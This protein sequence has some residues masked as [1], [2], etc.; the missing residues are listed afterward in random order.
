MIHG[1]STKWGLNI[2]ITKMSMKW[3]IPSAEEIIQFAG[4]WKL[5]AVSSIS[6]KTSS[7]TRRTASHPCPAP[8][9]QEIY[10]VCYCSSPFDPSN[11]STFFC[12]VCILSKCV[13]RGPD[14]TKPGGSQP[15]ILRVSLNTGEGDTISCKVPVLSQ[16]QIVPLKLS[17][18]PPP[19]MSLWGLLCEHTE[20]VSLLQLE[21]EAALLSKDVCEDLPTVMTTEWS[22]EASPFGRV[23]GCVVIAVLG[24]LAL[25]HIF[26]A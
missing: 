17:Y 26:P 16:P 21:Q 5:K 18:F 11:G 9:L 6:V 1:K 23:P 24:F 22:P 12:A 7:H 15:P 2:D 20:W 10:S 19:R 3:D 25:S 8:V 14:K 13:H 4:N